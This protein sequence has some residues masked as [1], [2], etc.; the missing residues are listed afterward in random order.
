MNASRSEGTEQ[1]MG[2]FM[3][4]G[5]LKD[6]D[7]DVPCLERRRMNRWEECEQFGIS[8]ELEVT[9]QR[10]SFYYPS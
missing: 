4:M 5:I 6:D 10:W 8:A 9:Q 1:E 3:S 7:A 2:R